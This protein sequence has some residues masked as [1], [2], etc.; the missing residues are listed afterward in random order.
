[1]TTLNEIRRFMEP[2]KMAM[3]GVS[4]DPKKFGGAI[5]KELREKG[6]ELYPI[7]PHADEIQ[8]VPCYHSVEELPAGVTRLVI[9]T[10][11]KETLDVAGAAVKK[12]ME[13]VWIQQKSDT[14]ESVKMI[15]DAGIPLIH[16]KCIMM[17]SEPVK[18]VHGF[19]RFLVKTFGGYP[20]LVENS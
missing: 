4:R 9:V 1:M 7:N 11:K 5:F 16:K 17:F 20:K 13:M 2:R 6:F 8:G 12:G 14:P 10:P 3:A 15:E 19:H 18:S